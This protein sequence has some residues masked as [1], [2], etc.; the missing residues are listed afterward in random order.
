MSETLVLEIDKPHF[1]VKLYENVLKI[2]LKEGAR[3]EILEALEN[4]PVL[5]E[6]MGSLLGVFVPLHVRLS[7]IESVQILDSGKVKL[8]LPFQRD[9]VIELDQKEAQELADKLN[10][11]IPAEKEKEIQSRSNLP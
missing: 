1:T 8:T 6:T 5:K 11:L 4:K 3:N 9:V 7:H 10:E 2:D